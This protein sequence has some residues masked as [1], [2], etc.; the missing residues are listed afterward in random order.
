ME[1]LQELVRIYSVSG[2]EFAI[3]AYIQKYLSMLGYSPIRIGDNLVVKICGKNRK[4]AVIFNAHVDTV[5]AG[6]LDAWSH[7]PFEGVVIE[8]KLYGLGASDEKATVAVLLMLAKYYTKMTPPCDVFLTF[9]VQEEIDGSGTK[10]VLGWFVKNEKSH[11]SEIAGILGEPTGLS[12]IEI[13]HKGNIFLEIVTTGDGGHGSNPQ[14]IKKHAVLEMMA[15]ISS[16]KKLQKRWEQLYKNELL[17]SP[18][19]GCA[20]SIF[21]GNAQSP[22]KFPDR[23]VATFDVRTVPEMHDLAVS[24]IRQATGNAEIKHISPPAP[25]GYTSEKEKIVT[26]VRNISYCPIV[27]SHWS[28]DLCFFTEHDIPAVVFGPG[29]KEVIHKPDEYCYLDKIAHCVEVYQNIVASFTLYPR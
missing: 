25:F 24:E 3:Q 19:L 13:A 14:A 2:S 20:T 28:N 11:Y 26:I 23:C 8:N 1:I 18:T 29:E 22:N 12:E 5:A 4:K 7:P 6:S 17:G 9:V 16:L 10:E 27:A 21:A 15:V